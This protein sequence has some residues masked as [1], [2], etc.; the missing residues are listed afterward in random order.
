ML[1][2]GHVGKTGTE[3]WHLFEFNGT[4]RHRD[5]TTDV[6]FLDVIDAADVRNMKSAIFTDKMLMSSMI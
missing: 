3:L 1:H 5:D 4:S 6:F 2:S